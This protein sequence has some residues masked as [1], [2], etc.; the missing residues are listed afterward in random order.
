MMEDVPVEDDFMVEVARRRGEAEG[1]GPVA[2]DVGVGVFERWLKCAGGVSRIALAL[3]E[4]RLRGVSGGAE[5]G[6]YH[7]SGLCLSLA[8]RLG[9]EVVVDGRIPPDGLV[10]ANHLGFLDIIALAAAG[11]CVFLAKREVSSW[12][13]AGAMAR[14]CGTVF[15]DRARR[16]GVVAA[17]AGVRRVL[18]AGV[19]V[20]I[21]PEGTSSEGGHV[22]PFKSSLLQAA[23]D[24]RVSVTPCGI[25]YRDSYGNPLQDVTYFGDK[26]LGEA[27][28][29]LIARRMTRVHLAF[30]S[31]LR[32]EVPR[33]ELAAE[34]H[35]R[36][37][38]L[39]ETGGLK[40]G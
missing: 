35:R 8:E 6:A 36:V 12:V 5:L 40:R 19:R 27:L 21:F 1:R 16:S 24:A 26:S 10:V 31:P 7:L 22:L 30:G 23:L 38:R 17:A 9:V 14:Q 18:E 39:V 25:F 33:A 28:G 20:V 37:S 32:A 29:A 13:L 4:G 11:P 34:M 2:G 15:V 3:M